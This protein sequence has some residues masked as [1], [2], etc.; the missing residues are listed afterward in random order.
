MML[1][2]SVDEME[3]LVLAWM[4]LQELHFYRVAQHV[5]FE[6]C[7]K[8]VLHFSFGVWQGL[9]MVHQLYQNE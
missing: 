7:V 5:M 4:H 8:F 6:T 3:L 2:L 9:L 1:S